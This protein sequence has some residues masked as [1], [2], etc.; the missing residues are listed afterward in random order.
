MIIIITTDCGE[1]MR[2]PLAHKD[3]RVIAGVYKILPVYG[4]PRKY[5]G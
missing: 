5:L 4:L 3:F 1:V 2:S